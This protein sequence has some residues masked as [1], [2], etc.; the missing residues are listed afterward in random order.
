M[1]LLESRN[2]IRELMS[3]F[4]VQVKGS[5]AMGQKDINTVSETV[6]IPLFSEVY[7]YCNLRNLNTTERTNYPAIDLV[8]DDARVAFQITSR[9]DLGKV[10]DTLQEFSEWELYLKYDRLFIYILTEK[11]QSYSKDSCD[12][13]VQ[14]KFNFDPSRDILDY[15]DILKAIADFQFFKTRR[16]QGI[17]EDNFVT[18]KTLSD[19]SGDLPFPFELVDTSVKNAVSLLR[20][21]RFLV[22]F[23]EVGSALRLAGRLMSGDLYRSTS[24]VKSWALMWCARILSATDNLDKAEEFLDIAKHLG[25]DTRIVDALITSRKGEKQ[26]ALVDL[27]D[28]NSPDSLTA[29]FLVVAHHDGPQGA[30]CWLNTL[31]K[32]ASDLDPDGKCILLTNQLQL[33]KW[34]AAKDTTG[35]LTK[36]DFEEV[37]TLHY[38]VAMTYLLSTV[39]AERRDV[40]LHHVPFDAASFPLAS[41]SAAKDARREARRHFINAAEAVK[42]L[43]HPSIA[44]IPDG[45]A[46]WLE[47]SES[48][49]FDA[50]KLRLENRL[51]N[52]ESALHFVP[53]GLQFGVRLD[54]AAVEQEI[55][56]HDAFH[57]G[58]TRDS[59]AARF[60]IARVQKSPE[61]VANYVD[62][63]Y[64]SLSKYF[65][66]KALRFLQIETL[67]LSGQHEKAKNCLDLLS[68]EGLSESEESRLRALVK[69]AEGKDILDDRQV[70]FEQTD[71]LTDLIAY[72]NEL[73]IRKK[74]D[75][76][77][78][79]G[80]KLF[81]RT[82][83]LQDAERLANAL[84]NA[85]R[86]DQIIELL[87]ANSD[88]MDQSIELQIINCWALY[89]EGEL[90]SAHS[91]FNKLNAERENVKY[92]NLQLS[93]AIA[94]GEW[95]S[96]SAFVATEYQERDRRS[97]RE[98][99][100]VARLALS[101]DSPYAKQLTIAAVTKGDDDASV[102]SSAYFLASNSGWEREPQ[103]VQCLHRAV[104]LS[105]DDGPLLRVTIED[106]LDMKPDWDRQG[107]SA[108]QALD[109]GEAPMFFAA[110]V[111]NKTLTNFVLFPAFANMSEGDLRRKVGIPAFSGQHQPTSTLTDGAIGLDC[112]TLLT[113][114]L[115]NLLDAVFS[116]FDTVNV[117]HSVLAWLFEEKQYATFHQPSRI[118]DA[119]QITK[120]LAEGLLEESDPSV[121]GDRE[122][123]T[124]I[125][126]N[127]AMLI[128]E[129]ESISDKGTQ[130]LVVRSFPVYKVASL[131]KEEADLS[132]HTTVLSSCQAIVRKLRQMGRISAIKE[133]DA[134]AYL[135]LQEKPWPHQPEITNEA[136]LYLDDLSV[137]Y[138]LR[139]GMLEELHAA[140]FRLIV[141]S[142][143]IS[144]VHALIGYESI[145]GNVIEAMENIR[146]VVSKGIRSGRTKVGKWRSVDDG[147]DQEISIDLLNLLL[148]LAE[149]CDAI[150]ADDRFLNQC[151]HITD[152][153]VQK[154][155]FSTLGLL[156]ALE[157]LGLI[158]SDHRLEHRTNLRLAGFYFVPIDE[159]ELAHQLN[160]ATVTNNKLNETLELKAIRESILLVRMNDWLQLPRESLWLDSTI[161]VFVSTLR[162]L[163]RPDANIPS[164]RARSDWIF[165]QLDMRGWTHC[166]GVEDRENIAKIGSG[167]VIFMLITSLPD[168]PPSIRDEYWKWIET[169][170]LR[171]IR[172]QN[173]DLYTWIVNLKHNQIIHI[174]DTK[175]PVE[176]KHGK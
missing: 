58:I 51:S 154:P 158:D 14:G 155:L 55:D 3:F 103:F 82:R 101:V 11:Q 164:V 159:D 96:L 114:S 135:Q 142:S 37:P 43:N 70:L 53:L 173:P 90:M 152:R 146:S 127:L 38:M 30:V 168:V 10:K 74:W 162:N 12:R 157:S 63:H 126:D 29:S 25:A 40:V 137:Y 153:G 148:V 8:D 54:L 119:R 76:L 97:A 20:K 169:R 138:L 174:A 61:D 69:R 81:E 6:L 143:L 131:L 67:S 13:I 130:G 52:L 111:L 104:E 106:V 115:L 24:T 50:G 125:G 128:A 166:F 123:S 64:K 88:I 65:D 47:L 136:I 16:I 171:P 4:V 95:E 98:L 78:R 93:I 94:L 48:D 139:L 83:S 77:C 163:W 176:E 1:N 18:D 121:K 79:Y 62:L 84:Y 35:A 113:L 75:L 28:I 149:D 60:A 144:E 100:G 87:R 116:A 57:G 105:G 26:A 36:S 23:D 66:S 89:F 175:L 156:D 73:E 108:R 102:L 45:Y 33:G 141:P 140:K 134:L 110:Q 145:S 46:L 15:R 39:P 2:R 129:A 49:L 5:G 118:D 27:A 71:S 147:E 31:G 107:S 7:G 19:I 120:L 41:S 21:S 165:D 42:R 133:R 109:R 56:R 92:R 86:F 112:T 160:A 132:E 72:V 80:E 161:K 122:L 99:I 59:V 170:I 172:E 124:Q 17:L 91:A 22:G 117:P 167:G 68:S 32:S 34:E 44:A 85:R 150:I 9:P 151:P